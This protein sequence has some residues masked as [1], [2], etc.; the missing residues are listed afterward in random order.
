MGYDGSLKFDTAIDEKG[1][2]GGIKK[3]GSIAKSGLSVLG[4]AVAGVAAAMGTGIAAGV[5]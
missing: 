4:G 1:F 5:K 2:N 3:L